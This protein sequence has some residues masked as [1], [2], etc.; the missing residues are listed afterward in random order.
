METVLHTGKVTEKKM[1]GEKHKM[2]GKIVQTKK[3]NMYKYS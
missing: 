1:M 2:Q 3:H